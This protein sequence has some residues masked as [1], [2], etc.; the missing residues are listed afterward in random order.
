MKYY[1]F[2]FSIISI[3][4]ACSYRV[5]AFKE[6]PVYERR[7]QQFED[8]RDAQN[9]PCYINMVAASNDLK[10]LQYLVA[11][12]KHR[13]TLRRQLSCTGNAT[14]TP[15][16]L[17]VANNAYNAV[18]YLLKTGARPDDA[19]EDTEVPLMIAVSQKH[20]KLIA[21]LLEYGADKNLNYSFEAPQI[22]SAG[23]AIVKIFLDKGQSA[24]R[25]MYLK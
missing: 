18:E 7:I 11:K 6:N 8:N 2:L 1:L 23:K 20:V 14:G 3:L 19:G 10:M 25:F 5:A 9:D 17:A 4:S 16:G 22:I 13:K 15:L 24:E 21:L 12:A